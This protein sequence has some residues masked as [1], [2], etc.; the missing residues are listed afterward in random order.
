MSARN[1]TLNWTFNWGK[2][3]FGFEVS[4]IYINGQEYMTRYIAY[5][6]VATLRLHRFLRGDDDRAPHSHPFWFVTFPF[7]GYFER[8]WA[9]DNG[10]YL[11]RQFVKAFRFHYRPAEYRHI[12]EGSYDGSPFWTFVISSQKVAEWGFYPEPNKFVPWRFWV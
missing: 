5:I 9:S 6:G 8:V 12:V 7:K 2:R 3:R 10:R 1:V 11:G 4:P